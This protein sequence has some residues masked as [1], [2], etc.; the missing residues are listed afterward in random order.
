MSIARNY[1]APPKAA[2]A[3]AFNAGRQRCGFGDPARSARM[4][5]T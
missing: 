1:Q 4:E 5:A 3:Y 2:R